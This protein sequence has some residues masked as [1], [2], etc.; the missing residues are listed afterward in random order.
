MNR[1]KV[2]CVEEMQGFRR[3]CF[4]RC[5]GVFGVMLWKEVSRSG[6][7]T[8]P[9][10]SRAHHS[11]RGGGGRSKQSVSFPFL[12]AE[13]AELGLR[14][15]EKM[16]I[17]SR[18]PRMQHLQDRRKKGVSVTLFLLGVLVT[19]GSGN[20]RCS[21]EEGTENKERFKAGL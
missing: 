2:L 14:A 17:F 3:T 12:F 1:S 21:G 6:G 4:L 10:G 8:G 19:P 7:L 20:R 5:G 9:L 15:Q 16:L 13:P 18:S 11:S